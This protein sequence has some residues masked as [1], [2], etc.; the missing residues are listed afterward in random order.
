MAFIRVDLDKTSGT[1]TYFRIPK[2]LRDFLQL[3]IDKGCDLEAL[4]LEL[5]DGK[6]DWT[7]G[8][9]INEDKVTKGDK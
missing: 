4:V 5:E 8:I 9:A 7:L 3:L 2:E 6:I 1:M